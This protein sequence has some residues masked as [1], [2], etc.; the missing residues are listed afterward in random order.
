[1]TTP[2]L[3]FLLNSQHTI[4]RDEEGCSQIPGRTRD[5]W[6]ESPLLQQ[7]VSNKPCGACSRGWSAVSR[8]APPQRKCGGRRHKNG[9]YHGFHRL[10]RPNRVP[11]CDSFGR[12]EATTKGGLSEKQGSSPR[13]AHPT[14]PLSAAIS[15]V[16]FGHLHPYAMSSATGCRAPIP[17]RSRDNEARPRWTL[18]RL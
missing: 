5:R 2:G 15:S 1:M 12:A 17:A 13:A 3:G 14:Q 6:F 10:A 18:S 16:S 4:G 11:K 7:R 9:V 8:A